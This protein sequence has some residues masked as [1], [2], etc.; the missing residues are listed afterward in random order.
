MKIDMYLFGGIVI[1]LISA[2]GAYFLFVPLLVFEYDYLVELVISGAVG[3]VAF[4][5]GTGLLLVIGD[6]RSKNAYR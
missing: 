5:F 2:I 1:G 3:F 6:A 4:M